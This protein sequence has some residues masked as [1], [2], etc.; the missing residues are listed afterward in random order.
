MDHRDIGQKLKLFMF[1][2]YS[3]GCPIWLPNGDTVYSILSNKIRDFNKQNGYVE[4]RTPVIWKKE[5]FEQSGHWDHFAKNMFKFS[6]DEDNI[7][8]LKPMN[9]P[10]HMLIFKSQ[11]WSYRDLPYRIHDQGL[12]HRNEVSGSLGGLTR[13]RSFCQDDGHI[14]LMESQLEEEIE[15]IYKMIQRVY[16]VFSMSMS[17]S[18]STR[19]KDFMG[20]LD[21]WNKAEDILKHVL[22]KQTEFDLDEGGGAFYGPKIDFKIKDSLGR[23]F[24][25][26]TIQLDFQLPKRF[27]L[28]Y[29]D[30]D[31]NRKTPIVVH[32]AMFG[33]FERFIGILLEHYA[34]RLPVWLAPVQVAILPIA[35]RH[36]D[37]GNFVKMG[38]GDIRSVIFKDN[39]TL[40]KKIMMA[41]EQHIPLMVVLGDKEINNQI[42]LRENKKSYPMTINDLCDYIINQDRNF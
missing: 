34:G 21:L 8:A 36:N 40:N 35:E 29:I 24:Q 12:L 5:L 18:L 28:E 31:N 16:N 14:F 25:T 17:C 30:A 19:P 1:H 2:P 39:I 11:H 4:V 7:Y 3:P 10:G 15:N 33:S 27:E 9:C 22:D 13:C 37:Y 20:D 38:L 23:E 41:E 42:T 6:E 32:R 26:A